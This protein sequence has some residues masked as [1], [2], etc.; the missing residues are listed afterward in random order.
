MERSTC[1]ILVVEDEP[2]VRDII[3]Q[4]LTDEGYEIHS[5]AD[6][7]SAVSASAGL[8]PHL[9]IMDVRLRGSGDV[10]AR[11]LREQ[12][13]RVPIV[14]MSALP[15]FGGENVLRHVDATL[16]KPFDLDDLLRIVQHYC[17]PDSLARAEMVS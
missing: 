12:L 16:A 10:G 15:N 13:P 4:F 6:I 3:S 14:A 8:D 2:V 17:H 9:V 1:R 5:A 11:V 7:V